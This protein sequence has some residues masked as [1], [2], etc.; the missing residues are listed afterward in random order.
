MCANLFEITMKIILYA[1]EWLRFNDHTDP[2]IQIPLKMVNF[3][4]QFVEVVNALAEF[5]CCYFPVQSSHLSTSISL[6]NGTFDSVTNQI[7]YFFSFPRL[8]LSMP[9]IL[10]FHFSDEYTHVFLFLH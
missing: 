8:S 6:K 2:I 1:M 9:S 3:F 10:Q 7:A 4:N 5:C